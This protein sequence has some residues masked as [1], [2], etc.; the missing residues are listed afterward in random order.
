VLAQIDFRVENSGENPA[1]LEKVISPRR[2]FGAVG[3]G[4]LRGQPGNEAI[5]AEDGGGGVAGA[6]FGLLKIRPI[7]CSLTVHC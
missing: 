6:R 7:V 4:A 3:Q 1:V 5:R 2:L